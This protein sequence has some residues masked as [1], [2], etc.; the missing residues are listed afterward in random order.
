[1]N[2]LWGDRTLRVASLGAAW[3]S[4]AGGLLQM[5]VLLWARQALNLDDLHTAL[6]LALLM[7]GSGLGNLAAGQLSGEKVEI[8]LVPLGG[9]LAGGAALLL[10]L[11]QGFPDAGVL[12]V[13]SGFGGGLFLAPLKALR[14]QRSPRI[15]QGRLAAAASALDTGA[16]MLACGLL[17]LLLYLG[18][19]P[20]LI[21]ALA[22]FST[23]AGTLY[24][25]LRVPAM[26]VR[27]CLWGLTNSLYPTKV[28]GQRHV[29]F[30][31]P[32]LMVCNHISHLDGL[33]VGAAT[34]RFIRFT[35]AQHEV[36]AL[37]LGWLYRLMKAIP[38]QDQSESARLESIRR[39]RGELEAGHAVCLFA[40]GAI[41]R[42]GYLLPF[43]GALESILK[44]LPP[45]PV[46]PVCVEGLEGTFFGP[47]GRKPPLLRWP[48][49]RPT[50]A[51][52][53]FGKPLTGEVSTAQA[54]RAVLELAAQ[55]AEQRI[56]ADDLLAWQFVRQARRCP[57]R[58]HMVDASGKRLRFY[59]TLG[60]SL[61]LSR[62]VRRR[63]KG[64]EMVGLL[65]PAT[66][67]GALANLA[68][69]CA[70][71]VPINLNFTA[72]QEAMRSAIAQC[73]IESVITSPQVLEKM[74]LP[75]EKEYVYLEDAMA[76]VGKPGLLLGMAA[77]LL[78]PKFLLRW[79]Y[80]PERKSPDDL[81]TI[82]FSS[83]STGVPKGIMLSHRN[84]LANIRSMEQVIG[85]TPQ[86]RIL[87]ILPFFHSFG[88]TVALWF[89]A[90][91]GFGVAYHPNP[92]DAKPIGDLMRRERI[93]IMISTP[94]FYGH[95]LRKCEASD[96]RSLRYAVAGAEKLRQATA[97][98][99]L[100]KFGQPL[101]EGYGCTE[102]S[103]VVAANV[104]DV[105]TPQG[106][107]VG[108]R[109]GSVGHP[110]PGLVVRVVDPDTRQELPAGSDGMVEVKGPTLMMGY[111]QLPGKTRE[112]V[113]DGWY[114]TGDIGHLDDYGFLHLTDRL[115]RFS[116]IGGEMVPH[117]RVEEA[118]QNAFPEES[119]GVAGAPDEAKGEHL[120]VLYTNP[121][122][123]PQELWAALGKA[124]LPRL[125]VPKREHFHL[126]EA[127]PVLGTGKT[128]LRELKRLALQRSGIKA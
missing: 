13:L 23:L 116:K 24:L 69:A 125:W 44:G 4:L 60:A 112:V 119:F 98:A 31:G 14:V 72:G 15:M 3:F 6:S 96:F 40:E 94:T 111:L 120:V 117:L 57:W 1:L 30:R 95:Y 50:R 78:L 68:V 87:G 79:I 62:W 56:Q 100:E 11:A 59:Q 118:L 97:S 99:F 126:V 21:L 51:S 128:D 43:S 48:Q 121:L 67:P 52:I 29:P 27:T 55:A 71:K 53:S 66:I 122:R 73:G 38:I 93:T 63:C 19:D 107:Q 18:L 2:L 46:I 109:M 17:L 49:R 81:A 82:I 86:D 54:R 101:Y 88:T 25:L 89:P 5:A 108:L 10:P 47:P 76:A 102:L 91:S 61:A 32:V 115:F 12:M 74:S 77:G 39:I 90:I 104:P 16:M 127:L 83:G 124:G 33:L 103:P 123:Q 75:V 8:G 35:I 41:S 92:T 58:I 80:C 22:G 28:R 114:M 26:A 45:I 85:L 113:R 110:L 34:Q 37:R 84:I 64:Q 7:A 105:A 106:R 9:A 36:E 70:G 20:A 65:M 42:T